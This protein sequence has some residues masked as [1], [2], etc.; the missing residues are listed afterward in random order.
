MNIIGIDEA[1]RGPLAGPVA[2]GVCSVP[3]NFDYKFFGLLK[4]S[5]KLSEKRREE[6]FTQMQ[7]LKKEGKINFS[8]ALVSNKVIDTRGISFAIK[9]GIE[10]VLQKISANPKSCQIFLDGSLKAPAEFINQETIIKGDEK[11][12]IISLAS[13]AA[14]VTRDRHMVEMSR[15][16]PVYSFEVHK[17]YGTRVHLS[18]IKK[19]GLSPIH[20]KS[21][22]ISV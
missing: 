2:V 14:K 5:K 7:V 22:A 15:K 19:L 17:G 12:P 11:I 16:Y 6:I 8:V 20:R 21:F 10:G 13:I 3:E 1:G 4:D 9:K 18:Q